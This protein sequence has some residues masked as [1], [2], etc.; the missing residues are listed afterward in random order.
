M[1]QYVMRNLEKKHCFLWKIGNFFKIS[2]EYF[3]KVGFH[4]HK[5]FQVGFW[6]AFFEKEIHGSNQRRIFFPIFFQFFFTF[7][8]LF[9]PGFFPIF[10]HFFFHFFPIFFQ[11]FSTFFSNFFPLF[12]HFF[13][14]V[15]NFAHFFHFFRT[16]RRRTGSEM[17]VGLCRKI[18]RDF[19]RGSESQAA[20]GQRQRTARGDATWPCAST[21]PIPGRR[22]SPCRYALFHLV[23]SGRS[24]NESPSRR[25][26]CLGWS[27]RQ[28]H[29]EHG[30]WSGEFLQKYR[31][32]L[33]PAV[34]LERI[35]RVVECVAAV[36]EGDWEWRVDEGSLEGTGNV[37]APSPTTASRYDE[38]KSGGCGGFKVKNWGEGRRD[39][40]DTKKYIFFMFL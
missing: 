21:A 34:H 13:F 35:G 14:A 9:F 18:R 10:F 15:E 5:T 17:A 31:Q 29:L 30:E 40:G 12:F 39:F 27:R 8:P 19:R 4:N 23:P 32:S 6:V 7:F 2:G 38:E 37:Q 26:G 22:H 28:G 24:P 1:S 11:F 36:F 33:A 16:E 20:P 25:E 3:Q